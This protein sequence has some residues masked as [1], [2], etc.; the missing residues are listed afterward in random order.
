[1]MIKSPKEAN[2]EP[3]G[4]DDN[5]EV[6]NISDDGMS[7]KE[8]FKSSSLYLAWIACLCYSLGSGVSAYLASFSKLELNQSTIFGAQVATLMSVGGIICSIILGKIN[9]KFGVK[10]GLLCGAL[11]TLVGYTVLYISTIN[12]SLAYIGAFIVGLGSGMYGVQSPLL[13]R[14]IV[15]N[16]DFSNIWAVIMVGNSLI[17]GGLFYSIALFYDKLGSFKGAFVMA[18]VLY[19]IALALGNISINNKKVTNN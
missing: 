10:M 1:M 19:L 17:G 11:F 13:I 5:V 7:K 9:D 2:I 8:A 16:K 4:A 15:G 6:K 18:S 14:N 12:V 3:F